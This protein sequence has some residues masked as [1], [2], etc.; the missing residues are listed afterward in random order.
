MLLLTPVAMAQELKAVPRAVGESEDSVEVRVRLE[1]EQRRQETARLQSDVTQLRQ[2]LEETR[3]QLATQDSAVAKAAAKS[4]SVVPANPAF[5]TI[6]VGALVQVQGIGTQEKTTAAQDRDPLYTPH[7]ARQI[8]LRRMR[9]LAGGNVSANTMFFFES[10]SPFLGEVT[11]GGAKAVKMSMFVQDAYIQHTFV[12]EFGLIAGLQLVG[13]TRNGLQ[14]AATLMPVNYGTYTFFCSTPAD[15]FVGRDVGLA[16]RGFLTDER[17][18]YRVGMYSGRSANLSAPFRIAA[19]VN[20][21]FLDREKGFF[22]TGSTLG[23]GSLLALGGGI[24]RQ[25]SLSGY[26]LD[27]FADFPVL[28]LG[29]L[30]ASASITFYDGGGASTDSSYFSQNVPKQTNVFAEIGYY[31]KH[32]GLQPVVKF[33]SQSVNEDVPRQAGVNSADALDLWNTL[34]SSSRLGVGLNYFVNG[35]TVSVKVMYERLFRNRMGT[36]GRAETV[37]TA[38][39]YLQVQYFTF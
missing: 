6:K 32:L 15:N 35:H 4:S 31:F 12:P 37:N 23:K 34:K 7:W 8:Q 13:I 9:I 14:S 33:E 1:A 5:P 36:D 29:S 26:A 18:E 21:N 25:S 30:T 2:L 28:G 24:D 3:R 38:E 16:A 10:D 17:L 20:Y 27:G 22:Y 11:G 39:V 19:R